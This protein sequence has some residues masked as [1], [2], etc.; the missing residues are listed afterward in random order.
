LIVLTVSRLTTRARRGKHVRAVF[1]V[2]KNVVAFNIVVGHIMRLDNLERL[3][4][5]LVYRE[6]KTQIVHDVRLLT[7]TP[8]TQRARILLHDDVIARLVDA[9]VKKIGHT[10]F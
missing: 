2:D 1:K 8:L 7:K 5:L 9:I 3:E 6:V 10:R 4:N